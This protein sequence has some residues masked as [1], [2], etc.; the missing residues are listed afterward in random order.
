[1]D[2]S[3]GKHQSFRQIV[4]RTRVRSFTCITHR[5]PSVTALVLGAVFTVKMLHA[6]IHTKLHTE[7]K[8]G[9]VQYP[10]S[11]HRYAMCHLDAKMYV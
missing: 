6:F 10:T 7:R 3:S 9:F 4:V 5:C 8:T 1:M 2:A 11:N